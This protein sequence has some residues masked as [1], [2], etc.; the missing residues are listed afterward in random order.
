MTVVLVVSAL[1]LAIAA[2]LV[3]LRI[4]LGPT[5]LDRVI[6]FEVLIAVTV[7]VIGLEAAVNQN[8]ATLPVL[9]VLSLLG[10]VGSASVASFT[11]GSESVE[12]DR[13]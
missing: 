4:A 12:E 6:A 8:R 13:A 2:L 1:V 11:S 7:C 10:F 5:L 9:V 3:V